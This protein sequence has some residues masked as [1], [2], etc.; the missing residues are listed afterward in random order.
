MQPTVEG[1]PTNQVLVCTSGH[2][3]KFSHLTLTV[4]KA[5]SMVCCSLLNYIPLEYFPTIPNMKL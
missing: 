5:N 3:S 4:F 1:L 2:T